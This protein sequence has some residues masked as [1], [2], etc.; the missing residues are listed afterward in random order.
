MLAGLRHDRFVGGDHEEDEVDSA[1]AGQHVLDELLMP[2]YVDEPEPQVVPQIE[3]RETDV[4]GDATALFF[5]EAVGIDTGEGFD[6][7]G[8]AVIDVAGCADDDVFGHGLFRSP[9]KGARQGFRAPW[10]QSPNSDSPEGR[11]TECAPDGS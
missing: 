1:D 11:R 4:N 10:G 3:V 5:L 8:L 6:Q 7:R 9:L 2:R